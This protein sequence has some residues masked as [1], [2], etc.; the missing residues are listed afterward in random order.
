METHSAAA[1]GGRPSGGG[2]RF[3]SNM[4][5]VASAAADF[6]GMVIPQKYRLL[7]VAWTCR[8]PGSA[9]QI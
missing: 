4:V 9:A 7:N 8:F 2:G 1:P 3:V 5:G 6:L